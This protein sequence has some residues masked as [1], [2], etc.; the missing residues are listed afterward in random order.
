M[1]RA[2]PTYVT[3]GLLG[4]LNEPTFVRLFR[5]VSGTVQ[6]YISVWVIFLTPAP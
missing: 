6:A 4:G 2:V 3:K 1:G 5:A